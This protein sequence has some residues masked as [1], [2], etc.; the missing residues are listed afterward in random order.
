MI[1]LRPTIAAID[2]LAEHVPVGLLMCV[3]FHVSVVAGARRIHR[4]LAGYASTAHRLR[5]RCQRRTAPDFSSITDA[6]GSRR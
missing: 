1:S 3:D 6:Q 2:V 5:V 4:I